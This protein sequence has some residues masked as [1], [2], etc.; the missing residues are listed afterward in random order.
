M[1]P[2]NESARLAG[3]ALSTTSQAAGTLAP[4]SDGDK[5]RRSAMGAQAQGGQ[6]APVDAMPFE[7]VKMS[8][9]KPE[10]IDWLWWGRIPRGMLTMLDGDPGLGKSTLI[11]EIAACLST[12][13]PLPGMSQP[14]QTSVLLVNTEDANGCTT[15]PRLDAAGADAERVLTLKD[16]LVALPDC[17][18][19]IEETVRAHG[20]G[21]IV[22]DPLMA[23]LSA[24][25]DSH[26]D[27][28]VRR[29]LAL[30]AAMAERRKVAIVLVRHLNKAIGGPALYRGEGIKLGTLK[31]AKQRL[32]IASAKGSGPGA[33]WS[34][35]LPVAPLAPLA[36]LSAASYG[37]V[38]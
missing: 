1:T 11:C 13:R 16:P 38:R 20:I 21:L 12:G 10:A 24:S 27:Q 4:A 15:R 29:A 18:P 19:R 25:I 17:V 26:R 32:G 31:R 3:Q 28:D 36:P 35:A 9:V 6:R 22:F 33:P 34:W 2:K 37:G 8:D 14:V 30:L 7:V 5:H 23:V